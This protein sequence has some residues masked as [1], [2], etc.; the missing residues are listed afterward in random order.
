MEN[1]DL[2]KR[3]EEWLLWDNDPDTQREIRALQQANDIR[4]LQERLGSRIR[5]GTAGLRGRMQA[6]FA[7]MNNLTVIQAAQGLAK[8]L[9]RA[10]PDVLPSKLIVIIGHDAR[11]NSKSFARV[12]ANAFFSSGFSV[13]L[14]EDCVP[15]PLV[16]FG[17]RHWQATA[18]IVITASHNPAQDNGF[19]VYGFNGA[20]I[21]DKAASAISE[22]IAK[23]E[24]PWPDAW[25]ST[26][27]VHANNFKTDL[28]EAY[29]Q[30]LKKVQHFVRVQKA[31][32]NLFSG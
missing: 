11:H 2:F 24:E 9:L 20:Q 17:M 8:H 12:A 21:M 14:F 25:V 1:S 31:Y 7:F 27:I 15:T 29:C 26:P 18:G 32:R 28:Q 23:N 19:K 6:G 5:F 10:N 22:Y 30:N 4:T 3:A 16:A 13:R